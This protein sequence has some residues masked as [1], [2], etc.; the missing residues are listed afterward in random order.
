MIERSF[1]LDTVPRATRAPDAVPSRVDLAVIGGGYTGL[2]AA[3]AFARK[4][5]TVA[6]FEREETGAGAS[7]R[8]AGQV[9]TGLK[10]EPAALVKRYGEAQARALFRISQ[11]AIDG[12]GQMIAT[13]RI[14]CDF[15]RCGHVQ[16]ASKRSHFDA[17]RDEQQL[18][19]R[20]F[21]HD[22][23]LVSREEQRQELGTDRYFG[24]LV[25]EAS[26]SLNPARYVHGL[27]DAATRA[28]AAIVTNSPV[29]AIERATDGWR[30]RT[31]SA[32]TL[33]REVLVATNGYVTGLT[34]ALQRRFLPIGSY[35]VVTAPIDA[36]L[37]LRLLPHGRMAFDSSNFLHYFRLT[38]DRRLLFGGRAEFSEPSDA[39]TH[40]AARIL[41]A[42][43]AAVFP[44]LADVAIDYVWSGR[45]A[46]TRDQLPHAGRLGGLWFA[47]GYCGHGI[48]MATRLGELVGE[49]IAGSC[50]RSPLFDLPFQPIPFLRERPWFLPLLGAYYRLMDLIS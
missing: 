29:L 50:V 23:R 34:P 39:S 13:E 1:W 9:L 27:A 37:A 42:D 19:A 3:R 47:G 24:A 16:A 14:D 6:V 10:L 32:E 30:L 31:P 18:L 4:R 41:R 22:V 49:A 7:S 8:N 33:A 43:M 11:D 15:V 46:F 35:I 21:G 25:D 45:V 48:A 40:R 26:A 20:V 17:L 36:A 2:S 28:G 44:E 12:L 38:P 5:G